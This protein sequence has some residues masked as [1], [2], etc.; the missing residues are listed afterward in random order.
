MVSK[1]KILVVDDSY[2]N[3][4]LL[5][6][7]LSAEYET[8]EAEDGAQALEQLRSNSTGISAV[9]LDLIMPR[10][11][12]YA[13]LR[14]QMQDPQISGIP[15]IVTTQDEGEETEVRALSMGACDFLTKPYRP[16]VILH[17]L[18]NTIRMRETA[19]LVNLAEKDLL[20]GVYN[21]DFFYQK[22]AEQLERDPVGEYDLLCADVEKFKLV[23]DLYG[24]AEGDKLLCYLADVLQERISDHILCG[25]MGADTFVLLIPRE[26]RCDAILLNQVR[27]QVDQYFSHIH[28]VVR[29][30]VYRINGREVPVSAMCDR[31]KLA[32][33]SI[34]GIYDVHYAY[35]DDSLREKMLRE[36]S[37]VNGMKSALETD[38]FRVYYQA[39]YDLKTKR[40][41]GSEALVRW[42]HAENGFMAPA[43]FIP[44]FEKNG[45]IADLDRF[46]WNRACEDLRAW[47]DAGLAPL[48]VS[49][50]VSRV[51]IYNPQLPQQL[52]DLVAKHNLTPNILH[53]EITESAYTENPRQL[54]SAV[55]EL[56]DLGFIIEMDDFGSGYS[57]L[58]MLSELPIDV[59]KLDMRFLQ[60]TNGRKNSEN[61]LSFIVNLAKWMGLSVVA[62]GI[63]TETQFVMLR[64]MEADYGQGYYFSKP[65]PRDEFERMLPKAS[66]QLP[67]PVLQDAAP[68]K[69]RKIMLVVDDSLT[70]RTR[71]TTAFSDDYQVV[72]TTNGAAAISYLLKHKGRVDVIIMDLIMPV[73][74]GTVTLEQLKSL[75]LLRSIP[76]VIYSGAGEDV[77]LKML[78]MGAADFV[79]KSCGTD[80]L[81]KRVA[82]VMASVCLTGSHNALE[83]SAADRDTLTGLYTAEEFTRRAHT[84]LNRQ[85]GDVEFTALIV[86]DVDSLRYVNSG[87]GYQNGDEVLRQIAEILRRTCSTEDTIGRIDGD[88]FGI[89]TLHCGTAQELRYRIA[90]ICQRLNFAYERPE[91]MVKISCSAGAA[92]APTHGRDFE[93]LSACAR[94][95]LSEAKQNGKSHSRLYGED[96]EM[97]P[98]A[99]FNNMDW[100]LD[101]VSDGVFVCDAD[102]YEILYINR[103]AAAILGKHRYACIGKTCYNVMWDYDKRCENCY[104][105]GAENEQFR[106]CIMK[107]DAQNHPIQCKGKY[108]EW[109]GAPAMIQYIHRLHGDEAETLDAQLQTM[110]MPHPEDLFHNEALNLEQLDCVGNY[111]DGGYVTLE[112]KSN[113]QAL[114]LS[115]S[116]SLCDLLDITP[117]MIRTLY[118]GD[119][120]R[121]V[122]PFDVD[123]VR[124]SFERASET[125]A[126]FHT[127][128]RIMRQD[129]SYVRVDTNAHRLHSADNALIYCIIYLRAQQNE[130]F[131]EP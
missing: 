4:Q 10:M 1:R 76:V 75:T 108:I 41:V 17:R 106:H 29:F 59:L 64:N 22:V 45:F 70:A 24:V 60:T 71:L 113:G 25:R 26:S 110:P 20:T 6:E 37:I 88:S 32:V 55:N 129:G 111:L 46:V 43:Q 74:D 118:D 126:P 123:R 130:K 68:T 63:E 82:N 65:V 120:F 93:T 36:Q 104:M 121:T 119:P 2:I 72:E 69:Q 84:I 56:R 89:V 34:K 42:L 40:I 57:S 5:C 52:L 12:G 115:F 127:V 85:N 73:M 112:V 49:V 101:E 109:N 94:A 131:V 53:L 15:V 99:L 48:P 81:K 125:G 33:D 79:P 18:A 98:L 103:T 67:S 28:I 50:N 38:Q 124:R 27:R 87:L 122:H 19:M 61:I 21:R 31:A 51:D 54:I 3:R 92:L 116:N 96:K 58:N 78:R 35:Y 7:I 8:L 39:K 66:A 30:G 117:D 86:I 47:I 11:D 13:F 90:T 14:E 62:E 97:P 23:N 95:A 100:L 9:L 83:E 102:S 107:Q 128:C 105:E 77:E 16:A 91:G 114:L 44:V 80:L